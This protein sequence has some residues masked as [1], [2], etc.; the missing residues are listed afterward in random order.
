M[1]ITLFRDAA[2]QGHRSAHERL[3]AIYTEEGLPMPDLTRPRTPVAPA[4]APAATVIAHAE[5]SVDTAVAEGTP[6]VAATS[7]AAADDAVQ[8]R[9][10]ATIEQTPSVQP[11]PEP[12]AASEPYEFA[13]IEHHDSDIAAVNAD[14][15]DPPRPT[16]HEILAGGELAQTRAAQLPEVDP[17]TLLQDLPPVEDVVA[18]ATIVAAVEPA[19]DDVA[20]SADA[21]V[22]VATSPPL[23]PAVPVLS[24]T[25]AEVGTEPAGAADSAAAEEQV[26]AAATVAAT[27]T[28]VATVSAGAPVGTTAAA[29][30]SELGAGAAGAAAEKRGLLSK[31]KDA[32]VGA[33]EAGAEPFVSRAPGSDARAAS[34][35]PVGSAAA[36][37]ALTA[38]TAA[39][40]DDIK[41]AKAEPQAPA[42][43]PV[44]I[45]DA[46]AA[47]AAGDL[48]RAANLFTTLAE[49]GD[50][51]AQAHVGYM[52]YTGEGV[53]RDAAK[54]VEWYRK[55]AVQGNKDAQYNIA[56]SYAFGE[57]V[58][59]SDEDAILWYRRAAEQ[60]S[61][62]AQFSL[63]VSYALG[64]GVEQSD[65]EAAKWY[66]AAA[67]QGYPAAQYNL[68]YMYRAGKGLE[69]NDTE[70]LK[71][72][73]HAAQN[74]HASAQYS[75]G[76]MYR[77]GRGAEKDVDE[78]IR[79][80][81]RAAGQGH[82]EARADLNTLAPGG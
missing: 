64:E 80:Y 28:T 71:W 76:Y 46:K 78:A 29:A 20:M 24:A 9:A 48:T 70:A 65:A 75:L 18:E 77:S 69:R 34:A 58:Q 23:E 52:T 45:A 41:L 4:G 66:Q 60:G 10:P 21:N 7:A 11:E 40:D 16:D 22:S 15:I 67:S 6:P 47:L 5:V 63:G 79:W 26:S 44:T 59:Q 62:I 8:D 27:T 32:F 51:E 13:I 38:P 42:P 74:G 73:L 19:G 35:S 12:S 43:R 72:F 2:R 33:D 57:G 49:R 55:S 1:V 50:A 30:A 14:E 37:E 82:P 3:A 61:A 31:L 39:A 56:V 17:D 68:A 36:P 54:A 25:V 53:E 81:R